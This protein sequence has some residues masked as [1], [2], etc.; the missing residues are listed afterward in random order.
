GSGNHF[1]EVQAVDAV[2][3]ESTAAAFGL[4]TGQICVM[5][6]C[7]SRGFGHQ[8]CTDHVREIEA[9]MSGHGI[10]VPDRQLACAPVDSTSAQSYLDAMAAAAHY[11][12]ANRQLLGD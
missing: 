6:H 4:H 9:A 3:D 2:F 5:I 7:G 12:R 1:L 8:V 10:E 11:A